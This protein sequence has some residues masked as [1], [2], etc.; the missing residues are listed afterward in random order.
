MTR[1]LFKNPP[2]A[3]S[4]TLAIDSWKTLI[5]L[6]KTAIIN[7]SRLLPITASLTL[8][9]TAAAIA[10]HVMTVHLHKFENFQNESTALK[11]V[12]DNSIWS[13]FSEI[14][15]EIIS[16][17][18]EIDLVR[19]SAATTPT[20]AF[21]EIS[22]SDTITAK[23]QNFIPNNENDIPLDIKVTTVATEAFN[24]KKNGISSAVIQNLAICLQADIQSVQ[25]LELEVKAL[26]AEKRFKNSVSPL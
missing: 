24:T 16:L 26:K 7:V 2:T 11:N 10:L 3:E 9:V 13:H 8:A 12:N 19:L 25:N 22:A 20:A 21:E 5:R 23:S 17:H 6:L 4:P 1:S 14:T 15:A 18:T